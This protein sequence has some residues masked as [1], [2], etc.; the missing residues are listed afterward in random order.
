MFPGTFSVECHSSQFFELVVDVS[1]FLSTF[2]SSWCIFPSI[3]L[4]CYVCV[5]SQV[6]RS[7]PMLLC[8]FFFNFLDVSQVLRS[9]ASGSRSAALPVV[10]PM[11]CVLSG[12]GTTIPL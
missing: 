3:S 11:H 9:S 1:N 2:L 8:P 12:I 4:Q 10:N 7:S 6:V 5:V